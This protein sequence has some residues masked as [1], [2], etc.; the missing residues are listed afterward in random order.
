MQQV[1]TGAN[2]IINKPIDRC[3]LPSPPPLVFAPP[4]FSSRPNDEDDDDD[5]AKHPER[6]DRTDLLRLLFVRVVLR[7]HFS[8]ISRLRSACASIAPEHLNQLTKLFICAVA[9]CRTVK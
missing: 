7:V 6:D 9:F 3:A 4:A 2:R 5:A 1:Q 8:S